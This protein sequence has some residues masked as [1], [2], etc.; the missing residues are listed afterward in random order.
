MGECPTPR[1]P[2]TMSSRKPS[3][4]HHRAHQEGPPGFLGAGELPPAELG[5]K[6]PMGAST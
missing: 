5:W 4:S 3:E 6:T 1:L 2:K